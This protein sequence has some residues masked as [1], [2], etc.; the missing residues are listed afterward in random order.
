MLSKTLV[1]EQLEKLP[2]KFSVEELIERMILIDKIQIGIEQSD[3][4]EIVSEKELDN[5]IES[6]F[7]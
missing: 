2:D 7:K 4:D 6:W 1:R 3:K 5:E